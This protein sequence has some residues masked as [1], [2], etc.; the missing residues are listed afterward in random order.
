MENPI[1]MDDFFVYHYFWKHPYAFNKQK[2]PI[3]QVRW[4]KTLGSEGELEVTPSGTPG[5]VAGRGEK[6]D[7]PPLK[8]VP[9]AD[10][11]SAD[12]NLGGKMETPGSQ[13]PFFENGGSFGRW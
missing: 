7:S 9:P 11:E 2:R 13:P 8:D 10:Y 3:F 6:S 1:K 4:K 5:D 12:W